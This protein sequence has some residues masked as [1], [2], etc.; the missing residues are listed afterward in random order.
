MS[1]FKI[2][3]EIEFCNSEEM[4]QAYKK[5]K[6]NVALNTLFRNYSDDSLNKILGKKAKIVAIHEFQY[7]QYTT[8]LP[9]YHNYYFADFEFKLAKPWHKEL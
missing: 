2:G 4:T 3:D 9:G 6:A 7:F 1:K 8:D 5:H